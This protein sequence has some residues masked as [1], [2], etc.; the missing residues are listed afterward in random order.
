MSSDLD[1]WIDAKREKIKSH[2]KNSTWR[3]VKRPSDK[4]ILPS[5]WVYDKKIDFLGNIKKYKARLVEKGY[6]QSDIDF[7]ET[8]SP[9]AM[10]PTI[11]TL[12]SILN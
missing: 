3:L 5:K 11:R 1:K 7:T 9:V 8:S 12:L 2:K 6:A 4:R 10:G